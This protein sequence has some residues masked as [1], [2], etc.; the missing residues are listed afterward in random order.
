MNDTTPEARKKQ[1]EVI[2]SKSMQ[3]RLLMGLEM[4]EEMRQITLNSI[5]LKNPGISETELKVEFVKRYYSKD[6]TPE[7]LADII[8]WLRKTDG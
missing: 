2:L 7:K 1:I 4:M 8:S 6:F 5:R 3:E